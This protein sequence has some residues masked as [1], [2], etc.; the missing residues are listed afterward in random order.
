VTLR[1]QSPRGE[2]PVG[3]YVRRAARI[4]FV[5]SLI[6]IP[7][8]TQ[9]MFVAATRALTGAGFNVDNIGFATP[10]LS[11]SIGLLFLLPLLTGLPKIMVALVYLPVMYVVLMLFSIGFV[12]RLYGDWL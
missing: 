11:A 7:F 3:F 5:A 2:Y 1:T 9:A 8:A 4:A 12:G 10:L 6:V